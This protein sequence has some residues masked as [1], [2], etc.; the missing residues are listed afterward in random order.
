MKAAIRGSME[1]IFVFLL[2]INSSMALLGLIFKAGLESHSGPCE[3]FRR[4]EYVLPGFKF[5]CWLGEK[6]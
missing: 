4:F 1:L 6:I 3:E 5:G 2:V